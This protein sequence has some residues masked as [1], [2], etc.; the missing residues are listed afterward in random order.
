MLRQYTY[1]SSV[2][3]MLLSCF[4]LYLQ[5]V[6]CLFVCCLKY[7]IWYFWGYKVKVCFYTLKEPQNV[8]LPGDWKEKLTVFQ[9]IVVLRCIRSDKVSNLLLNNYLKQKRE[10][11]SSNFIMQPFFNEKPIRSEILSCRVDRFEYHIAS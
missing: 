10:K 1:S 8:G 5:L 6:A 11:D 2:N 3:F 4:L 7:W 9:K